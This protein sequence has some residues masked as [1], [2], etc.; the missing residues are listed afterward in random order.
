MQYVFIS[1]KNVCTNCGKKGNSDDKYCRYCGMNMKKEKYIP[2][3]E[4]ACCVYGPPPSKIRHKCPQCGN[5][6]Y[7][8]EYLWG[9]EKSKELFCPKCSARAFSK[10][11]SLDD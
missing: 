10:N 3:D 9:N 2:S 1:Y 8:F 5:E 11:E 6:W 7:S 4:M